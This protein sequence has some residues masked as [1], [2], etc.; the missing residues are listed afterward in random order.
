MQLLCV[1]VLVRPGFPNLQYHQYPSFTDNSAICLV[2]HRGESMY[3]IEDHSVSCSGC[4]GMQI[5]CM[6][7]SQH[8][9]PMGTGYSKKSSKKDTI[10]VLK[11]W[12]WGTFILEHLRIHLR[13]FIYRSLSHI[14][15]QRRWWCF[16]HADQGV[17]MKG[18]RKTWQDHYLFLE[19]S[20]WFDG[21]LPIRSQNSEK[22]QPLYIYIY[23]V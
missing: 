19:V 23:M 16:T 12:F 2:A 1:Y 8:G 4:L 14:M 6:E 11:A 22:R 20:L 7:V 5:L 17:K 18:K 21:S 10:L 15:C 3:C 9:V 13:M